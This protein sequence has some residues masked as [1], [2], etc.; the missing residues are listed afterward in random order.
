MNEIE[1]LTILFKQLDAARKQ[2]DYAKITGLIVQR[3]ED[4]FDFEPGFSNYQEIVIDFLKD[5]IHSEQME[6]IG[7]ISTPYLH[8]RYKLAWVDARAVHE[9][10]KRFHNFV[11][12]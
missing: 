7:L 9:Q 12:K 3:L 11:V 5:G 1:K 10:L 8:F 2:D 6:L 4:K